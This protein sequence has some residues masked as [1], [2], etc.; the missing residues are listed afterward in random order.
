LITTTLRGNTAIQAD[1][2]ATEA[3]LTSVLKAAGYVTTNPGADG[4]VLQMLLTVVCA[5]ALDAI[6]GEQGWDE[7]AHAQA[8][9]LSRRYWARY[10]LFLSGLR[11][12]K[13]VLSLGRCVSMPAIN[14]DSLTSPSKSQFD[15]DSGYEQSLPLIS[16]EE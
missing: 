3:E 7:N 1:I 12:G 8:G 15:L 11:D 5:K 16:E 10:E 4:Y 14:N 2:E 13:I 9:A 6:Y